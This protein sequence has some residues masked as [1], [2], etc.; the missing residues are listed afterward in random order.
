VLTTHAE[1]PIRMRRL[2]LAPTISLGIL[3]IVAF[4]VWLYG[5]GVLIDPIARETGWSDGLLGST[6]GAAFLVAGVAGTAVGRALDLRGSRFTF[7][8]LAL[9]STAAL[10]TMASATSPWAFAL[11]GT[12]GGGLVGAGGYYNAT[13]TVMARLVPE[14]RAH[15]IT[16]I[17]L[18]GAF[19]S[20][21]F[22][23][24]IGWMVTQLGWRPTVRVLA[25]AV[26]VAYLVAAFGVPDI[27]PESSVQPP[28]RST[29]REVLV[30]PVRRLTVLALVVAAT[31]SSVIVVQQVPAMTDAGMALTAASAY[32]GARGLMQ[33]AGRLPLA[34]IVVRF[35]ARPTLRGSYVLMGIGALLLINAGGAVQAS[36]Y[37]VVAGVGIGAMAAVES[38]HIANVYDGPSLGTHLGAVGLLRGI[39]AAA[40]PA[41]GGF[42]V[43]LTGTRT[44]TLV[45]CA[46]AAMAAAAILTT[47]AEPA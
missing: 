1:A 39:G 10:W 26:G 28:L 23:P 8:T 27:R 45:L 32:A 11:A 31:A 34:P 7:A 24:L 44:T 35:G 37:V 4:G 17:T 38:I 33:L 40:G 3:S 18:W 29:L 20:P 9:L 15:G 5:Y 16:A 46:V 42:L 2:P 6:Y 36:T 22:M 19:A 43:D 47:R 14:H 21:V 13:S 12:I 30:G 25:V 41:I